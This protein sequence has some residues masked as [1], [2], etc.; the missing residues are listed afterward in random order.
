M[1]NTV[2][3]QDMS[4]AWSAISAYVGCFALFMILLLALN[5]WVF[6]RIL[7]KAGFSGWL[8]LLNLLGSFGT[9]AILLVLAFGDWP[10]FQS[11]RSAPTV[12]QAPPVA[13]S[14]TPAPPVYAPPTIPEDQ[15]SAPPV[16][17]VPPVQ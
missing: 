15:T 16:P 5:I 13:P 2:P 7:T 6:W 9:L 8:S 3:S 17:P 4:A 11:L 14:Y 1:Y 10:V 12:G